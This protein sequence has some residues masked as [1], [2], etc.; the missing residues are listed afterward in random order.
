M[1]RL[2]LGFLAAVVGAVGLGA[3]DDAG[4]GAQ[5]CVPG[6]SV[7]CACSDGTM[8]AQQ[9]TSDGVFSACSCEDGGAPDVATTAGPDTFPGADTS[10]GADTAGPLPTTYQPFEIATYARTQDW[11]YAWHSLSSYS[12][13]AACGL[14][15]FDTNGP[16]AGQ[17]I[18]LL[19]PNPGGYSCPTEGQSEQIHAISSDCP[20]QPDPS[21]PLRACAYYRSF[22]AGGIP[23]FE[24]ANAG[25]M[26]VSDKDG[27]YCTHELEVLFPSGNTFAHTFLTDRYNDEGCDS[28]L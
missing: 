23:T 28:G 25:A 3:C 24:R 12:G 26:V 4:D 27:N 22:S 1:Q 19:L 15:Q 20:A 5:S 16:G 21:G 17:D 13:I 14:V 6:A 18:L 2:G 9:C 10:P 8:G 11:G 7:A